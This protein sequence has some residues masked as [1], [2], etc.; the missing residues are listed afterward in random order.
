MR[1]IFWVVLVVVLVES[2]YV[3]LTVD[4]RR[5]HESVKMMKKMQKVRRRCTPD[6]LKTRI[7]YR[8]LKM[9]KR[10]VYYI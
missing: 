3:G 4:E 6:K 9:K 5:K 1:K 2:C 8:L 7:N 10:R